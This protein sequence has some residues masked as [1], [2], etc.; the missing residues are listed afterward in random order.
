M[1]SKDSENLKEF[2]QIAAN[3][4]EFKQIEMREFRLL[5]R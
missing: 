1:N 3:S 5:D 4:R 2:N